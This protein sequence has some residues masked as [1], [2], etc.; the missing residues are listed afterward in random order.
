MKTLN[1]LFVLSILLLSV[2]PAAA[3]SQPS[4][5][6]PCGSSWLCGSAMARVSMPVSYTEGLSCGGG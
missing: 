5:P 3:Q 1:A 4:T 6:Q 2:Y